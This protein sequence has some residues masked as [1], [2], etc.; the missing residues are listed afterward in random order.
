MKIF[1]FFRVKQLQIEKFYHE[2][3]NPFWLELKKLPLASS[4]RAIEQIFLINPVK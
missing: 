3:L 2:K 1:G 4:V